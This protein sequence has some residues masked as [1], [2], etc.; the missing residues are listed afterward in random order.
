MKR[1]RIGLVGTGGIAHSH[2]TGYRSILGDTIKISAACDIDKDRVNAFCDKWE[3]PHRFTSPESLLN[4][5]EVDIIVMLTPPSI[6]GEYIFPALEKGIHV[7]VE[8]PFGNSV[9]ECVEYVKSAEKSS[10]I[11][12]VSQN[13]RFFPEILWAKE[14]VSKEKLGEITYIAHDHFQ[15]RMQTGGWRAFE[16]RLEISIFS[17]HILDRLRWV[18]GLEPEAVSC[19]THKSWTDD[20]PVGE[21]FTDL[22]IQFAGGAVGRM[23]SSWYSI[24][25]ECRM[26]IDG[27][28]GTLT[29][30]RQSATSDSAQGMVFIQGSEPYKQEFITQNGYVSTFGY[31][32]KNLIEAIESGNEPIHSGRDNLQTMAIIDSAYLSAERKG[33]KVEIAEIL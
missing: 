2:V 33:A 14:I 15:W 26:R 19:I 9:K 18:V 22:T 32:M 20:A 7:L 3:I 23:T 27:K 10:A 28:N 29:I 1:H 5:G 13:M 30:Q 21:V 11:L 8:K 12:A 17:V 24:H 16:K 31:S 4:S 6:R 25:P